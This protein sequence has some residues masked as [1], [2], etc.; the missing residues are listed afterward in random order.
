MP[1]TVAR[2]PPSLASILTCGDGDEDNKKGTS[3]PPTSRINYSSATLKE[4]SLRHGV[5]SAGP[6]RVSKSAQRRCFFFFFIYV[7]MCC[8]LLEFGGIQL[9]FVLDLAHSAFPLWPRSLI[10]Q[11]HLAL[12]CLDSRS[13]PPPFSSQ[14]HLAFPCAT[15]NLWS[16]CHGLL[17]S[18]AGARART[19]VCSRCRRHHPTACWSL[20]TL[21]RTKRPL[22]VNAF[23]RVQAA[24][25]NIE[26]SHSHGIDLIPLRSSFTWTLPCPAQA[27]GP[28]SG[29]WEPWESSLTH[30]S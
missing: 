21:A 25:L 2:L 19:I 13:L 14:L 24:P 27:L 9:L 7:C 8:A 5:E 23:G 22:T 1:A 4:I 26:L 29:P 28:P 20:A 17:A 6:V 30:P 10:R 11:Q 12:P 16:R 15:A 3:M 18:A